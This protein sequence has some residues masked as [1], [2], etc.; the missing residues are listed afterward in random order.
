MVWRFRASKSA[1]GWAP[2]TFKIFLASCRIKLASDK[3]ELGFASAISARSSSNNSPRRS[4]EALILCKHCAVVR[5]WS[6][7]LEVS[8]RLGCF[9]SEKSDSFIRKIRKDRSKNF[10]ACLKSPARWFAVPSECNTSAT[11]GWALSP[12]RERCTLD[13]SIKNLMASVISPVWAMT[14]PSFRKVTAMPG[15]ARSPCSDRWISKDKSSKLMARWRSPLSMA[16]LHGDHGHLRVC[17]MCLQFQDGHGRHARTAESA[18]IPGKIAWLAWDLHSAQPDPQACAKWSL[19]QDGHQDH[20]GTAASAGLLQACPCLSSDLHSA[21][22][23]LPVCAKWPQCPDGHGLRE[24]T[25]ASARTP[26]RT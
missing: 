23:H 18:G 4:T 2:W 20:A 21:R 5:T 14:S 25:S 8:L 15:W 9:L 10:S 12:Y 11:F 1:A 19:S 7:Q 17:T 16:I 26:A 3:T 6:S 22:L 24:G 13:D